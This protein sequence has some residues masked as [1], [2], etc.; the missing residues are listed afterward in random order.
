M[1][2]GYG[3]ET[4]EYSPE[5][6]IR[7]WA[8]ISIHALPAKIIG[9]FSQSKTSEFYGL[10]VVLAFLCAATETRL[11]SAI[12]RA[13]NPRVGI[14][15]LLIV[16]FSP[17]FFYAS[18]AFLPSSFAMYTSALGLTSFMD[19]HGGSKTAS[20]IMWFGIGALLGWPF[21]GALILPFVMEEWLIA[22]VGRAD[23]F[24]TFRRYL[25][26]VVR[27][28]IVLALQVSIDGFFFHKIVVV[29]WRIVAYNVF[30]G[31]NRGPDIF[32]TEPWH[33][34]VRNLLLNFNL[35]FILA[36]A[37]GPF[38]LFQAVILKQHAIKPTLLR[39]LTF[40]SPFYL[41]LAIF[42]FQPHKEERFMYPAY[43]FLALNAAMG[44][45]SFLTWFGSKDSVLFGK[46][47][48]SLKLAAVLPLVLLSL[49]IGLFRILGTVTAYRAPLEVYSALNSTNM[50]RTGDNVCFGKDWYRFPSSHLLPNGTHAKFVKSEFNGLLPGEFHEG[51]TGFGL[52][53][54]TWLIPPGMNDLNQE[55]PGKYIQ[56][57]HCTYLVDTYM[58]GMKLTKHEPLYTQEAGWEKIACYPFLDSAKTSLLARTIWIPD[59]PIIPPQYRRHWGE[60]CLLKRRDSGLTDII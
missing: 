48:A 26:G 40:L 53:P 7:S 45:H 24:N 18:A 23:L 21:A 55:D 31:N 9:L 19:W 33:F 5:F 10:R 49:N 38:V 46:I 54:G 34:Y 1:N 27:C 13:L 58:P 6:S 52:F 51:K 57:E 2:H 59:L 39:A 14:I 41:W 32:G 50:V 15:Y 29:P 37:S 17:G 44:F 42:T 43:P 3:L 8:Y 20:G 35:W 36:V 47:P 12:S 25:D 28:L 56:V 11:Y 4:W 30:G 16:A 60:H 22:V